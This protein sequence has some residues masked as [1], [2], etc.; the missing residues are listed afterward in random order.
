MEE[1]MRKFFGA[2]A[3]VSVLAISMP[4]VAAPQK[5]DSSIGVI[6]QILM[7]LRKGVVGALDTIGW[8]KP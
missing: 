7:N 1:F 5:N 2:V 3:V 6:H 8:P 4:L